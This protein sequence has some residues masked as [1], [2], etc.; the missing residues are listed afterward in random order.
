MMTI[1]QEKIVPY[2]LAALVVLLVAVLVVIDVLASLPEAP[3]RPA[4]P[5]P[6]PPRAERVK[7]EPPATPKQERP[8]NEVENMVLFTDVGFKDTKVTTGRRFRTPHDKEPS[9]QWCYIMRYVQG[10]GAD[11]RITLGEK[12]GAGPVQ[13]T[14]LST[15]AATD[16]GYALSDL[17]AARGRCRFTGA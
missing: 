5:P 15:Q 14:P 11:R 2:G 16:I 6:E 4:P 10:R 1:D 3:A 9:E 13:W 17:E 8:E 7:P 12:S